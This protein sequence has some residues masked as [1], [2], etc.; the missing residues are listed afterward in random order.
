MD[1]SDSTLIRL[2]SIFVLLGF[3]GFF[4]SCEAAFFSL[5]PL[6]ISNLRAN[7]GKTGN[8]VYSLLEHPKDLLVAIYV[9]NELVNVAISALSTSIAYS[10]L[11]NFGISVA[12]GVGTF[13]LLLFGEII[14][15]TLSLKYAETYTLLAAY[16]LKWFTISIRPAQSLLVSLS[17]MLIRKLDLRPEPSDSN[18]M[19]D[20]E[21]KTMVLNLKTFVMLYMILQ[22][23]TKMAKE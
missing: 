9:G 15:K 3:S 14:P 10:L 4:S 21:L 2:I 8:L 12:I 20:D 11:G 22:K 7:K 17:E 6:Q 13:I 18:V 19:S 1:D 16:P 23:C 5:N